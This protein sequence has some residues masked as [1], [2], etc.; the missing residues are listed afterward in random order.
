MNIDKQHPSEYQNLESGTPGATWNT[1]QSFLVK[2][3]GIENG[4]HLYLMPLMPGVRPLELKKI[5]KQPRFSKNGSADKLSSL[6][7]EVQ[8]PG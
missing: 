2:I 1:K 5:T 7:T 6:S 4:N 3:L 8:A